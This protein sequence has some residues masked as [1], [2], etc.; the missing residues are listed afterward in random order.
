MRFFL[1]VA[2]GVLRPSRVIPLTEA[3]TGLAPAS[4]TWLGPR[5]DDPQDTQTHVPGHTRLSSST[6][7]EFRSRASIQKTLKPLRVVLSDGFAG[8]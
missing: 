3:S 6:P 7:G 4:P 5:L 8:G 1:S 2:C